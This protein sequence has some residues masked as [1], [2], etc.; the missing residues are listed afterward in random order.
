MRKVPSSTRRSYSCIGPISLGLFAA[1]T[2]PCA[3]RSIPSPSE[4]LFLSA[5]AT[6]EA[7][8]LRCPAMET[9]GNTVRDDMRRGAR[10]P[11]RVV[12]DRDCSSVDR[13]AGQSVRE[14]ACVI[15]RGRMGLDGSRRMARLTRIV[16]TRIWSG[17]YVQGN[18]FPSQGAYGIVR[19]SLRPRSRSDSVPSCV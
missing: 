4:G 17:I 18:N 12:T 15:G 1:C 9:A 16:F 3:P 8:A 7:F 6:A 14:R 13:Q 11:D 10:G 5:A 19:Q 2:W